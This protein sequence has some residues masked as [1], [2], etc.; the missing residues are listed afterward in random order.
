MR[1]AAAER[2]GDRLTLS[3]Y[4]SRAPQ[5]AGRVGREVV[6]GI[7]RARASETPMRAGYERLTGT[8]TGS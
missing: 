1:N 7:S 6:Q 3:R 8:L 5:I 2:S 4:L